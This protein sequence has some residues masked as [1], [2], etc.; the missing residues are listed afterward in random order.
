MSLP[1]LPRR[2]TGALLLTAALLALGLLPAA[3]NGG[4]N[5]WRSTLRALHTLELNRADR[6]RQAG[7]YYVGLIDGPAAVRDELTLCMLG[8]PPNWVQFAD[9]GAARYLPG[10]FLQF[11]L[12][13]N[14]DVPAFGGRFRTNALG[15]RDRPAAR[16]KPP[17]TF[18]IALLG[19]SMDMGWGVE[20]D[21]TYENRLE[22]WLN[23]HA[24]KR[25]QTRRFEVLNF[26]MAA[27]SPLHR[28]ET[29]ER[30]VR[31]FQPDLVLY[32]ITRL[33]LRL[34]QIHVVGLLQERADLKHE[35]L[36]RAVAEAGI[37]DADLERD[38]RGRLRDKDRVKTLIEPYLWSINDAALERLAALC[39]SEDLPIACLI[40]PRASEDDTSDELRREDRARL[41]QLARR[42]GL[43]VLDLSAAFD[44]EVPGDVEIAPWDDHPNELGHRLLFLELARRIVAQ[45]EIYRILFP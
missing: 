12:K 16:A 44:D 28:L 4:G 24:A 5:T 2:P 15:L 39:R 37:T 13:P 31:D 23:A 17:G 8:K 43:P 9:I 3:G 42:H 29:F 20:T 1:G 7:G 32:S 45:P 6:A 19:S 10:D 35:F 27:Y 25:G 18:R 14:L 34:L 11:E 38:Y 22:D 21:Q 26:A 40:V 41:N 33:D 30:K 36:R